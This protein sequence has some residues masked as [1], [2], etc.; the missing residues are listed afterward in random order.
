M[1]V[2]TKILLLLGVVTALFG[3][4]FMWLKE[5]DRR[6]FRRAA[7]ARVRERNEAFDLFR[8][9]WSEPLG[10]FVN[11]RS[12]DDGMVRAI[13]TG[14]R[15]WAEETLTENA[16]TSYRVHA[17]WLY[18]AD[19]GLFFS[20]NQLYSSALQEVPIPREAHQALFANQRLAHFFVQTDNSGLLEVRGATVHPSRDGARTTDPQGY[21]FAAR[22][23]SQEDLKEMSLFTGN[24]VSLAKPDVLVE[25]LSGAQSGGTITFSRVLPGWDGKPVAQ[26]VVRNDSPLVERFQQ[27]STRML[28]WLIG[29]SVTVLVLSAVALRTWVTRPLVRVSRTLQTENTA[30]IAPLAKQKCEFGAIARMITRFFEQRD[31]LI[32]EM[33]DRRAA[34]KALGESEEQLRH[35]QKMEAV[36]RL[37]GGVAH[38]FNNLLTAIIGYADL[39]RERVKGDEAARQEIELIL[40]ASDQAASLTHQLLAFSR[41]QV[42]HPKVL[43]LNDLVRDTEKLL[44]RVI[45]DHIELRVRAAAAASRVR[46]DPTQLQQ[47]IVNLAVNARDAMP[48]GG[49]LTIL[50][51]EAFVPEPV[52]H[53]DLT[54]PAGRYVIL[55]VADTG[56][57]MDADTKARMFEPFFTTKEAGKG[58][59]LGLATVYGIVRQSGGAIT[60][61][62]EVGA[63]TTFVIHLPLETAEIELAPPVPLRSLDRG[64]KKETVLVVEDD[65]AVCNL[66]SSVLSS[67]HYT[68]LRA[69]SGP[70]ALRKAEEHRGRL[71][72]LVSDLVMPRMNGPEVAA[73]LRAS[74]PEMRVLFVSGYT[75]DLSSHLSESVGDFEILDKPFTPHALVAKVAERLN[76]AVAQ[77]A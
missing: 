13:T 67:Y 48:R 75:D 61:E 27:L 44:R 6:E 58:T 19:R 55:E 39:L 3:G 74:H 71:D 11:D 25:P 62:S 37:A 59:G 57:G 23:W 70:E 10:T 29:F 1:K 31:S 36:G 26:I 64:R 52:S 41:K 2:R 33:R 21:L 22:L 30:A 72:L 38:D 24:V 35:A 8:K 9:H 47:V 76:G 40:K 4:G 18:R 16:L 34:E 65:P 53:G 5:M 77:S 60:V 46:A 56:C 68:V 51:R 73:R 7:E 32:A 17:V 15:K 43:E 54:L 14:D 66:I 49:I 50:T 28:W 42:L 20:Q 12:C 45:G 63:G 69:G